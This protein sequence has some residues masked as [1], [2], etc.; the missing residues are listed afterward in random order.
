[1]SSPRHLHGVPNEPDAAASILDLLSERVNRFRVSDHVITYCNAAWSSQYGVDRSEVIGRR[2]DEFL[3]PDELEGLHSQLAAL[4]PHQPVLTDDVARA[5][6]GESNRW[7]Q[8]VD[9][10]VVTDNG[11]EVLS[12]GRDVTDRH[13]A[14]LRLAESEA[15]FRSLADNASDVVWRIR[16]TPEVHVDYMSPSVEAVLGYPP[17]FFLNDFRRVLEIA[18]PDTRSLLVEAIGGGR[19]P[20]RF[21]LRFRHTNGSVVVGETTTTIDRSIVQ[22]VVRDVTELRHLQ[23]AQSAEALVDPLT[24]V[25]NRRQFDRLLAS[26]LE[27]TAASGAALAVVYVDVDHFKQVNDA[28][29]HQ[30][31]DIVLQETARRLQRVVA[32]RRMAARLGGDEFAVI[33]DPDL[34]PP[35]E[36]IA[37]IAALVRAPIVVTDVLSLRCTASIGV[38]STTLDGRRAADLLAAADRAMYAAKREGSGSA[39]PERVAVDDS[40]G[41]R[42]RRR[43]TDDPG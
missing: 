8:W 42:P 24:G 36:L 18:E 12:V 20:A 37:R 5:V 22:G 16:T 19:V 30:S 41:G 25:S 3:S 31:G 10:Y 32:D 13:L 11:P 2:L 34:D 15:R 43:R 39:P 27:R 1:M 38:G 35:A 40:R 21:D 29:G 23:A 28:F 6:P 4:G 17:S 7:L 14:E 33:F 26:E 9:R